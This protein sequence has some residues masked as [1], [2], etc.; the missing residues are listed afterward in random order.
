MNIL[1]SFWIDQ[2]SMRFPEVEPWVDKGQ[3]KPELIYEIIH[4]PK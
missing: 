2:T 1:P 3:I 4:T